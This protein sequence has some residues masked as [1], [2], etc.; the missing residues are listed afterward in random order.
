MIYFILGVIVGMIL[1]AIEVVVLI[2]FRKS[3]EQKTRIVERQ[4]E[5]KGPR[6]R[7]FIVDI[8][9]EEDEI[10]EEIIKEN[11]RKGRDTPLSDLM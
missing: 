10:R 8:P 11:S 4:I 3:I 9:D 1:S 7:G 6:P 5:N 2:Y